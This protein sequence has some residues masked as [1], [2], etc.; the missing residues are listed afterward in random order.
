MGKCQWRG[1]HG[2]GMSC[3]QGC[4][5]GKTERIAMR[6]TRYLC[7]A[8]ETEIL[9]D[10]SVHDGKKVSNERMM[11]GVSRSARALLTDSI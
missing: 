7:K 10:T 8:G 5:A 1:Y 9:T 6:G 11:A 2:V 4:A 3:I